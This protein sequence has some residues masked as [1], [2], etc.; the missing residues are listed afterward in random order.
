MRLNRHKTGDVMGRRNCR[1]TKE[2]AETQAHFFE[3]G[4]DFSTIPGV[5]FRDSQ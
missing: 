4:M 5:Q 2:L 3:N 1:S